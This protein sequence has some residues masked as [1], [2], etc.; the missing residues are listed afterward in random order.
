MV[1]KGSDNEKNIQSMLA[2][3]KTAKNWQKC[4][5]Y[6]TFKPLLSV[7]T[8]FGN[9]DIKWVSSGNIECFRSKCGRKK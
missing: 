6:G 8:Q 2:S 7:L 4:H 1:P 9:L 3:L 5:F